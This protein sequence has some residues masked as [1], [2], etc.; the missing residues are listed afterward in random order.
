MTQSPPAI[1]LPDSARIDLGRMAALL[2]PQARRWDIDAVAVCDSTNARLLER[3]AAGA[4]TGSVLV[5]DRQTAGRG[6]MGRAWLS[7]PG[8][9]LTFSLL[10]RFP[11]TTALSGLSLA[12][13]V[14]VVRAL[15]KV[16]ASDTADISTM[17]TMSTM[18]TMGTMGAMGLI[19][20]KWPNDVLKDGK[21]LGGILIELSGSGGASAAAVIGIGINLRLPNDLPAELRE[22]AAAFDT[23][24]GQ[25]LDVHQLLAVLL[26]ELLPVLERFAA[27]GFAPLREEWLACHAWAGQPVRVLAPHAPPIEGRCAG[28][29]NDGALLLATASGLQRILSGDVSLRQ[30]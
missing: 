21:K 27:H 18:G 1:T 13:G 22:A 6:R 23:A 15:Q 14:A 28:I 3:A 8:D 9:S 2:G 25:A 11:A 4:P 5:A 24:S 30:A 16:G 19:G 20:L 26:G 7:T 29:D 10:W 17:S 12:V